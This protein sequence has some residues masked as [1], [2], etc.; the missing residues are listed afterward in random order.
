MTQRLKVIID[1][2][3]TLTAE[4]EQVAAL[5]AKSLD[6]LAWLKVLILKLPAILQGSRDPAL[7]MDPNLGYD[8]A[9]ELLFLP[10]ALGSI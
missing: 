6:M 10:E 2:D 9:A 5:A 3:G 1:W 7:A 4:E 8:D